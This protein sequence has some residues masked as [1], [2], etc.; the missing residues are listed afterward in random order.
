MR[1]ERNENIKKIDEKK[2]L[3][4]NK[5]VYKRWWM[6]TLILHSWSSASPPVLFCNAAALPTVS[7]SSWRARSFRSTPAVIKIVD[8][9]KEAWFVDSQHWHDRAPVSVPKTSSL[10]LSFQTN[11]QGTGSHDNQTTHDKQSLRRSPLLPNPWRTWMFGLPSRRFINCC[12]QR[13]WY[14]RILWA[15]QGLWFAR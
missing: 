12:G 3:P 8:K 4:R 6:V 5:H 11:Q 15:S 10:S 1:K 2:N 7:C 13:F 14:R 9:G